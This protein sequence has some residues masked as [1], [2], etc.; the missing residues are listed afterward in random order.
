VKGLNP[1]V[2]ESLVI[3]AAGGLA[4]D[5]LPAGMKA[6]TEL[7]ETMHENRVRRLVTLGFLEAEAREL[8]GLHTPNF[9]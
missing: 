6:R 4:P 9:M 8:S 1:L 3:L 5:R 2:E 7:Y